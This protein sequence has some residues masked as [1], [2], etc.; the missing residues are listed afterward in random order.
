MQPMREAPYVIMEDAQLAAL[1]LSVTA[2]EST[3]LSCQYDF[4]RYSRPLARQTRKEAALDMA[5]KTM[6]KA[7]TPVAMK[8]REEMIMSLR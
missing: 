7:R 2:P 3:A 5:A 6:A 4:G 1:G 8:M